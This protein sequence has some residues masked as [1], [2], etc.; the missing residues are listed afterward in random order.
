[1]LSIVPIVAALCMAAVSA[2][3]PETGEMN[4]GELGIKAA[5]GE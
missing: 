5:D 1:M 3:T 4:C 2:Q